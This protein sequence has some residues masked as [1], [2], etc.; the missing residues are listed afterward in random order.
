MRQHAPATCEHEIVSAVN[1]AAG[2]AECRK[3]GVLWLA[4]TPERDGASG[5]LAALQEIIGWTDAANYTKAGASE[6]FGGEARKVNEIARAAIR[7]AGG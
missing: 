1:Y 4:Y 2:N 3:C 6:G 7:K 5:L